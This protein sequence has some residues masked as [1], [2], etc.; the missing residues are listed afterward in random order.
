MEGRFLNVV[1]FGVQLLTQLDVEV[2]F[3]LVHL[4]YVLGRDTVK[5]NRL[6]AY[7][8][9]RNQQ[10]LVVSTRTIFLVVLVIL[11]AILTAIAVISPKR[12]I[13]VVIS[14]RLLIRF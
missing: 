11:V 7:P 3:G 14:C 4:A 12:L 13:F 1:Y 8:H 2:F 6:V 5:S 9:L 10:I